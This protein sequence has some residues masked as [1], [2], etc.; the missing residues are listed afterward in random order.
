MTIAV[1]SAV[2]GDLTDSSNLMRIIQRVEQDEIYN[3]DAQSHVVS[4]E[5][6]EYTTNSDALGTLRVLEAVRMPCLTETTRNNHASTNE[7]YGLVQEML[8]KESAPVYW[9]TVNY[10]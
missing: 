10:R 5:A 9:V 8:Q 6:P 2:R 3:L 4:F 1:G 7:L